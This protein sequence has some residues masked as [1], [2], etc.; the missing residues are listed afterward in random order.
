MARIGDAEAQAIAQ[1]FKVNVTV[2]VLMLDNNRIGSAGAQALAE[3]LKVNKTLTGL[4][5]SDNHIGDAGALAIAEALKVNKRL[6]SLNLVENQIG[7]AG[8]QAIANALKVNTTLEMLYL[9]RN[10]IGSTGAQAI[11]DSLK[12]NNTLTELYFFR[13]QIGDAGAQ[14]IADALEV[15]STLTTLI[16]EKNQFGNAGATAIAEALRVNTTLTELN[17]SQNAIADAGAQMIAEAFNINK[18]LTTLNLED[19]IISAREYKAKALD[20]FSNK[21]R[22]LRVNNQRTP[23]PAELQAVAA[24]GTNGQAR[25]SVANRELQPEG[26][27]VAQSTTLRQSELF[28]KVKLAS[29][30]LN[31]QLDRIGDAEAQ[32]I[33]QALKLNKNLSWLG[34]D[35]NQIGDVGAQAIA[36]ALKVNTTVTTLNLGDNQIGNAGAQA[37]AQALKVNTTI[38]GLNL[39]HVQISDAGAQT[40]AE[41]L[42]VNTTL[43]TLGLGR[44]QIGDAGAQAIAEALKV[45]K[46]LDTLFLNE[47]QIGDA[48]AQAIAEALKVNKRLILLILDENSISESAINALKQVGNR[49]CQPDFHSQRRTLPAQLHATHAPLWASVP[50][51]D[52]PGAHAPS[53]HH[54]PSPSTPPPRP[55]KPATLRMPNSKSGTN[56]EDIRQLQARMAQLELERHSPPSSAPPSSASPPSSAPS[57]SPNLLRV[58]LQVLSQA[59]DNFADPKKIGGGGFGNVYSGVWNGQQVAVKRMAANSTQGAAQFEAE[60]E[61]LSRF[62]HPNI[63]IIMCYAQEDNERCLVYELMPNGSVRDRLDRR[64]GTL[65]LSWQ[66]RQNIAT[67]IA[68]AMH[69]VQTAIPRQP[70]FHLDLKTDNVL[71]DADFH[72]KVADFGLTRSM[73]AQVDAHSYIRTQTVQGTLQYICP[74]YRDEGKVSIKTDVYSYGMILLELATGQRPSIDLMSTVR[75]QLKRSRK[76]DSVLDKAIDWSSQDKEAAQAMAD[77]AVDCLDPARVYRPSFGEILRRFS[78]E[79]VA[80]NEEETVAGSDRECLVCFNAPTNAK[81]IP[82]CHACVCVA[83]AQWMIQRQDKCMICRV[84]PTSFHQG[85]YNKT[86][87]D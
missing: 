47:N 38:T 68:N 26:P 67:D 63:V 15:N 9:G 87:V 40:I 69:F 43:T 44:N 6:T 13:N 77:L 71:L 53:S 31:L 86:F 76:I 59:T 51:E 85:T 22:T 33:A 24:S 73:P 72:A 46:K 25:A 78:G 23:S 45:N 32:A 58:D 5:L 4:Y 80:E 11:A 52:V 54:A 48:G 30:S 50:T 61:A 49:A 17:L 14:A 83:C 62:R 34:L 20:K 81:L 70:L 19:N 2:T 84:P 27:Q 37:I 39:Q 41:A 64:G 82:C 60:L 42:K 12:V 10:P 79:E 7:D 8:G 65:A 57:V 36:E 29:G 18:T 75:H 55:P 56:R 16:L 21:K 3:A 28:R 66:Q 1:A 74:Q 35:F